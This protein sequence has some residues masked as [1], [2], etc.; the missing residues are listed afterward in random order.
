[1]N[2]FELIEHYFNRVGERNELITLGIDDDCAAL[3]IPSE[4]ELVF[5]MDTLDESVHFH[6]DDASYQI[7]SR[8]IRVCI[9]DLAAMGSGP[10]CFTLSL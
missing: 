4:Q 8:A 2:E 3:K 10:L 9:S 1:M 6:S 7:A 5:S